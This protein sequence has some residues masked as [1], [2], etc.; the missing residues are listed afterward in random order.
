MCPRLSSWIKG[1]PSANSTTTPSLYSHACYLNIGP[2]LMFLLLHFSRLW[3]K[4]YFVALGAILN[5]TRRRFLLKIQTVKQWDPFIACDNRGDCSAPSRTGSSFS[6]SLF[7]NSFVMRN[8]NTFLLRR[9]H[10]YPKRLKYGKGVEIPLIIF[11]RRLIFTRTTR[12][13]DL[14][15]AVLCSIL[16]PLFSCSRSDSHGK[17]TGSTCCCCWPVTLPELR[18]KLSLTPLLH[19]TSKGFYL[20]SSGVDEAFCNP[21]S[22]DNCGDVLLAKIVSV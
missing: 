19:C 1:H 6:C 15:I 16:G 11:H 9:P 7:P 20:D 10:F 22:V 5:Q 17:F 12:P 14:S 18:S 21:W 2:P 13:I 4:S 3:R 8:S